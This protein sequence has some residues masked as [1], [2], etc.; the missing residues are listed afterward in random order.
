MPLLTVAP[1]G[2]YRI[3]RLGLI[4]ADLTLGTDSVARAFCIERRVKNW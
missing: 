4:P 3:R 2:L 1:E